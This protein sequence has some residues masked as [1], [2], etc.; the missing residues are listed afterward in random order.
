MDAFIQFLIDWGYLGMFISAFLAGTVIPFSSEVVLAGLL[1][2]DLG[3]NP[4]TCL[5]A[6]TAGNALGSLTCYGIGRLGKLEWLTKYFNI[7]PV[8]FRAMRI[9]LHN[10]SAYMAFFAFVPIFGS[11]M[12]IALG[13]LRSNVIT[14]TISMVLGKFLRYI[15]V[16]LIAKGLFNY[17]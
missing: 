15:V 5:F 16:I 9:Y 14:V 17:F 2:P 6:A 4:Y 12:I 8:K 7:D 1:H 13:F 11:I 10:K 3:L